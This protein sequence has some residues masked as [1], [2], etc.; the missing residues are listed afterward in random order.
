MNAFSTLLEDENKLPYVTQEKP[1][2]N[3]E[4]KLESTGYVNDSNHI[5]SNTN[6]D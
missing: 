3:N 4:S 1:K 2:H 5:V 6:K